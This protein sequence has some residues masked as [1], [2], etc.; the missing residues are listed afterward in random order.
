MKIALLGYGRMGQSIENE[1]LENNH[2]ITL[3]ISSTN[4]NDLTLP[5]LR[6]AE[7]AID[8][9]GPQAAFHH[10]KCGLEAG[11]PVVSGSTGWLERLPEIESLCQ[12]TSG[13]F[14]Y[15]SNFSIGVNLFFQ[16]N[17][18]LSK[19][20]STHP[21]YKPSL[22]ETHHIHKK[23]APSGTAITLANDLITHHPAKT[24]WALSPAA[25]LPLPNQLLIDAKRQGNVTGTHLVRWSSPIDDIEIKHTAHSRQGFVV[26]ALL[27]AQWLIGKQGCFG[28]EDVLKDGFR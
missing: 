22:E 1:A 24:D 20:L 28:M 16:L 11:I 13:A 19:L 15:A 21:D 9:S 23:D 25:D 5:N 18:Y 14:L 10:I 27:A 7:V 8:F 26:G 3:K 12:K 6:R 4:Q 2:E 17:K